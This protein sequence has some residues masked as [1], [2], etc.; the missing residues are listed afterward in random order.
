[1]DIS[2]VIPNYNGANTITK[3]IESI[4]RQDITLLQ[5][6]VIDDGSS[7]ASID[8][9]AKLFPKVQIISLG[10]NRG[11][12]KARNEGF[13][14]AYGELILF[15]DSDVYLAPQCLRELLVAI[16]SS[17]IAYPHVIFENGTVLS[18]A[19][20][21]EERF[22]R[23]S[24]IFIINT[25]AV[26]CLDELFDEEYV[27]YFEDIDF[28]MRCFLAGLRSKYVKSAIALHSSVLSKKNIERRFYLE[29]RNRMY[30]FIKY[31]RISQRK[32]KEFLIPDFTTLSE[33]V[34][35]AI[36]NRNPYQKYPDHPNDVHLSSSRAKVF[37]LLVKSIMWN[38]IKLPV[39]LRK[40][41]I[42]ADIGGK[43]YIEDDIGIGREV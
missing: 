3:C 32:R 4:Y 19:F 39:S 9:V 25:K 14:N 5:V 8:I 35:T 7:D 33:V 13:T 2:V 34:E 24:P 17:D 37:M 16:E 41:R 21:S 18:P 11:A 40:Q 23:R 30:C 12:A 38:L 26:K 27:I 10:S 1:M 20:P 43:R 15:V 29:T 6:I 36:M 22:I 31:L 42:I 28:F